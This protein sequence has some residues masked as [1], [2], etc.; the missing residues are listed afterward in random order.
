MHIV[1]YAIFEE[2]HRQKEGANR[3]SENRVGFTLRIGCRPPDG[4]A[5]RCRGKRR[6]KKR[7][8]GALLR[9]ITFY[10]FRWTCARRRFRPNR[11][12]GTFGGTWETSLFRRGPKGRP[13]HPNGAK[14]RAQGPQKTPK[15]HRKGRLWGP[16]W[17]QREAKAPKLTHKTSQKSS[18]S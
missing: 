4:F 14:R 5:G 1:K 12:N 10:G 11:P 17:T 7:E 18:Q 16:K 3:N 9:N 13:R 6:P 2:K 8:K 15:S